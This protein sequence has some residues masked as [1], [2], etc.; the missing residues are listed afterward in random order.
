M[1]RGTLAKARLVFQ[2]PLLRVQPAKLLRH[3]VLDSLQDSATAAS[4]SAAIAAS[5]FVRPIPGCC[6][7]YC[8][9]YCGRVSHHSFWLSH[10]SVR[11]RH[12]R[13]CFAVIVAMP[14][15]AMASTAAQNPG[16]SRQSVVAESRHFSTFPA[17]CATRITDVVPCCEHRPR[18][19][20]KHCPRSAPRNPPRT[21]LLRS[22]RSLDYQG[23]MPWR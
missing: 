1:S 9:Q 13:G 12:H 5:G 23:A 3:R 16:N 10:T 2:D 4:D 14:L 17:W 22:R 8:F 18:T 15:L 20:R 7:R 6:C 21:G 11:M 19:L